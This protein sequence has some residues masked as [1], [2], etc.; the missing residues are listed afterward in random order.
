MPC[1]K[2]LVSCNR[3]ESATGLHCS[4]LELCTES[5]RSDACFET[6]NPSL[7]TV[8]CGRKRDWDIAS[9]EVL[10]LLR[11]RVFGLPVTL[12]IFASIDWSSDK[13]SF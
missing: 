10:C 6:L 1:K 9:V 4:E 5:R 2:P 3:R 13:S 8:V 7:L 11:L 12:V